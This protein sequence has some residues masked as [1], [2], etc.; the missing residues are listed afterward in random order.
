MYRMSFEGTGMATSISGNTRTAPHYQALLRALRYGLSGLAISG[1]AA[2]LS[3]S[4][5]RAAEELVAT[6]AFGQASN[7]HVWGAGPV[8]VSLLAVARHEGPIAGIEPAALR[9]G[10]IRPTSLPLPGREPARPAHVY[11]AQQRLLSAGPSLKLTP[12]AFS[13][14]FRR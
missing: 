9:L 6:P 8:I 3:I 5:A 7:T 10:G 12:A 4:T 11:S 14:S 2:S 1:L 13:S